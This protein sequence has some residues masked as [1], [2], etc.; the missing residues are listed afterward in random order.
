MI[1]ASQATQYIAQGIENIINANQIKGK[2]KKSKTSISI[3]LRTKDPD[4]PPPKYFRGSNHHP[5]L[6]N[7]LR[8]RWKPW[9]SKNICIEFD[10]PRFDEKGKRLDNKWNDNV[11]Q[12]Y[13]ATI[14][15]Y[16]IDVYIYKAANLE[17]TDIPVV[18]DAVKNFVFT[19][20]YI[21]PF[22]NNDLK[23]AKPVSELSIFEPAIALILSSI[24]IN[25]KYL[26]FFSICPTAYKFF[27]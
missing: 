13:P 16:S 7:L 14:K 27:V 20:N 9:E 17:E 18:F 23:K 21:D 3:Y 24:S 1:Q 26:C 15:P 11:K 19:G 25:I 6:S 5:K 2:L 22:A 10:E 8:Y 4:N 12:T